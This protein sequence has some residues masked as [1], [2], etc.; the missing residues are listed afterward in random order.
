VSGQRGRYL[1]SLALRVGCSTTFEK[2]TEKDYD[3]GKSSNDGGVSTLVH[4][5]VYNR[6]SETAQD[7]RQ[8]T[9]SPVWDVVGRVAVTDVC[10][11]EVALKSDKPSGKGEQQLSEWRVNVE[12]VLA[13]EIIRG[14][15]AKVDL[16]ETAVVKNQLPKPRKEK[17]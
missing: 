9:H 12:I 2:L 4:D 3:C 14:E 10:E 16:V 17:G 15:F 13:P 7:G 5:V 1:V 6:N 11:V 8:S